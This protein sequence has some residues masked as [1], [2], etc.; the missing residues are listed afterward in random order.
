MILEN[1][2]PSNPIEEIKDR[3][4]KYPGVR[5]DA[6]DSQITIH[7]SDSD[8][9]AVSLYVHKTGFTVAFDDGWHE[10]FDSET[11][12]LECLAFGLSTA[13]RL[14]VEYRGKTPYRWA[15]E[16]FENGQWRADS[17]VGLLLF[18]FW[19]QRHMVYR[20]NSLI[21]DTSPGA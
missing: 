14:R 16:G 12:A 8:G 11:E 9:F 2:A 1:T 4:A 3:L 6:D 18:P 17:T 15:V 13:C 5:Y 10:E 20:Q 7:P 21:R 19:R